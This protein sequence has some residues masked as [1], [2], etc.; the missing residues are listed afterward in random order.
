[1]SEAAVSETNTTMQEGEAE[2][3]LQGNVVA[4]NNTA[5]LA[6][7]VI[8]YY[9]WQ[10]KHHKWLNAMMHQAMGE[11]D[12]P[13]PLNISN[14]HYPVRPEPKNLDNLEPC[15]QYVRHYE[16]RIVVAKATNLV[17]AYQQAL[18]EWFTKLLEIDEEVVIYPWMAVDQQAGTMAI[19]DPDEI[20]STL[21]QHQKTY[22]EG[23]D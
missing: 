6:T 16:L 5:K 7:Q 10:T 3:T 14:L 4:A 23:M 11:T 15:R 13:A 18:S 20:L 19:E 2:G 1:M 8:S 22:A 21:S 12:R 9:E 17:E